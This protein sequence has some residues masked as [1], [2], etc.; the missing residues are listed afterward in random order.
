M[1]R[2]QLFAPVHQRTEL[3]K[4]RGVFCVFAESLRA[5]QNKRLSNS[6]LTGAAP[7]RAQVPASKV[8]SKLSAK[9]SKWNRA[10]FFE[11]DAQDLPIAD[12]VYG[13]LRLEAPRAR[14][15]L[16]VSDLREADQKKGVRQEPAT[17]R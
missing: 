5:V 13:Q 17:L 9:A 15:I 12:V 10:V 11:R 8:T 7:T 6:F 16:P 14:R 1:L 2:A 3:L 4:F